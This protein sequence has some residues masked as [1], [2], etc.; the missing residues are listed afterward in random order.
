MMDGFLMA[1]SERLRERVA[2]LEETIQGLS[3]EALNWSPG[4]GLNSLAVL[5]THTA[6]SMRYTIGDVIAGEPSGRVRDSEF[7][8]S[9]ATP[10]QLRRRLSDVL[11]YSLDVVA[12]IRPEELAESRFSPQHNQNFTV[13]MTL[14]RTLDHLTEHLGH[15]EIT[16]TLWEQQAKSPAST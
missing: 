3:Q 1:Y 11:A 8:V 10:E 12:R 5:V 2:N 16:R 15:A 9:D 14:L 4:L 13:A 7:K 6:G